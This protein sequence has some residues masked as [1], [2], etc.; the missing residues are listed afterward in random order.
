MCHANNEKRKTANDRRNRT[1]NS[2]K[3]QNAWE[4][5]N[6]KILDNI[7]SGYRQTNGDKRK[8]K[9]MNTSGEQENYS[10]SNYIAEVQGIII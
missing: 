4:K 1:T 5:R 10:K 6:L 9:K 8:N 2:R 3:N 7:R